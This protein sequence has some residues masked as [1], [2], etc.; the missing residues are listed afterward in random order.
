MDLL[1]VYE[2]AFGFPPTMLDLD[3]HT[4]SV[5]EVARFLDVWQS[6]T[7]ATTEPVRRSQDGRVYPLLSHHRFNEYSLFGYG[8][9]ETIGERALGML[10]AHD[11]LVCSD[12]IREIHETRRLSGDEA[13]AAALTELTGALAEVE[14]LLAEGTLRIQPVRPALADRSRRAVLKAFG[15]DADMRVFTNFAE[16]ADT[17]SMFGGSAARSYID[18]GSELLFNFGILAPELPPSLSLVERV[19]Q[20]RQ[21][22]ER[23]GRSLLHLSWQLS[24]TSS[25]PA[26][27]LALASANEVSLL[28]YLLETT[29]LVRPH[30]ADGAKRSRHLMRTAA[31]EIPNIDRLDLS[32]ADALAIRRDDT[33]A[34]FRADLHEALDDFEGE[35]VDSADSAR[36]TELFEGRMR[37]ASARL[38][39]SVSGTSFSDRLKEGSVLV[40]IEA[41][42]A[43]TS[44][45]PEESLK[46]G[47]IAGG[48]AVGAVL[49]AWLYA[50][51]VPDSVKVAIRYT[52]ALG[53]ES[54]RN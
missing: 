26:A 46:A 19:E 50:R 44:T 40:A 25:D 49:W 21:R 32:S 39:T 10:L 7:E 35:M 5:A 11:G 48:G 45:A 34:G 14:P 16:A 22:V 4:F 17:A 41:A 53:A 30:Q 1:S 52:S 27:D 15:V 42:V 36:P 20:T 2:S 28:D 9:R 33:F 38:K 3:K 29:A 51:R 13:A 24:V 47:A 43:M 8:S 18:Q 12:P 23:L 6:A 37:E 54:G 31:G